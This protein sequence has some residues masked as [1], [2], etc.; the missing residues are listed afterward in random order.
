MQSAI[1]PPLGGAVLYKARGVGDW[2]INGAD[3]IYRWTPG[4]VG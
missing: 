1:E 2:A 3:P 4:A